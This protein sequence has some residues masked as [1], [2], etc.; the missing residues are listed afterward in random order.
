MNDMQLYDAL[1]IGAG[2]SGICMGIKLHERGIDNILIAEKSPGVGGTWHDN[3]YPG[4]CCDVPSVLYSYSFEPNPDWS[5]HYSPHNEIRAYLEHCVDKYGL[6]DKVRCDCGV[7]AARFDE[8]LGQ[9]EVTLSDGTVVRARTLVSAVGQLNVP[10][11]PPFEGREDFAGEQFHSARWD[12]DVDL[13]GKRVAIIGNAA[14]ALQFI[15]PVAKEAEQVYVY[16]RSAN[17]VIPRNDSPFT[18]GQKRR[19]RQFPWW[20][21]IRRAARYLY[22]ECLLFPVMKTIAPMQ[23]LVRWQALNFLENQVSDPVLREKLT[24]KYE[25]GCKRILVSDDYYQAMVRPNVELVTSPI[26]GIGAEGVRSEDEQ[27]RPADVLIYGTGFHA[28]DFLATLSVTGRGGRTLA[29]HWR[30]GAQAYRGVAV[31]EFPNLF[32]LYGPNTN[33][34]H[35]SIIFMVEQ[36]VRYIVRCIDKILSHDLTSLEPSAAAT[37]RYNDRL[38]GDLANT[39]WTGD[40][41]SWYKN[42]A[43]LNTNNWP[44]STTYFWWHMR[45]LDFADF[46]MRVG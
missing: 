36:Q 15:P 17:Y 11:I 21:R 32:M 38:Q 20:L 14:S 22:Q 33:L 16:Q 5:R 6:R 10:S 29:E 39:V 26:T 45:D 7:S 41:G 1:I 34:G 3:H 12:H 27:E 37:R 30:D 35:S 28:T 23:K 42:E 8:A 46:D 25:I 4:A 40:C 13:K 9:W 2:I 31:P 24:P 43:G 44:H 19:F 18:D